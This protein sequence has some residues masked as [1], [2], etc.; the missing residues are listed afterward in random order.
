MTSNQKVRTM[1][2]P[3][4]KKK[5]STNLNDVPQFPVGFQLFA[6]L[7]DC[8]AYRIKCLPLFHFILLLVYCLTHHPLTLDTIILL[9]ISHIATDACK[10]K[11]TRLQYNLYY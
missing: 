11:L 5:P 9:Y 8:A 1:V 6:G 2:F 10:Y 7:F 3:I 4:V